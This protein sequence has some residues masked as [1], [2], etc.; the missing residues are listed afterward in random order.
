MYFNLPIFL[1]L[2]GRRR[3]H[4]NTSTS[5]ILKAG[6]LIPHFNA[7]QR[8][9]THYQVTILAA[10]CVTFSEDFHSLVRIGLTH[11]IDFCEFLR[12]WGL[13]NHMAVNYLVMVIVQL[14]KL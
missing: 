6:L 1:A 7:L 10:N 5:C 8:I 4:K 12:P 11:P 14:E 13:S 9:S 2:V 3:N